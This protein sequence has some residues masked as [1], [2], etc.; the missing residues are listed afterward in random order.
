[1]K[2]NSKAM[3]RNPFNSQVPLAFIETHPDCQATT[4]ILVLPSLAASA[5][6]FDFLQRFGGFGQRTL[7]MRPILVW[8]RLLAVITG[9]GRLI[10]G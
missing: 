1:M 2:G 9:A 7:K 6:V 8:R 3:I 5:M 10:W 4:I